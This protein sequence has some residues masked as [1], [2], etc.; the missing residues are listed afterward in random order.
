MA[1][2]TDAR[3]STDAQTDTKT[4]AFDVA[5]RYTAGPHS[6]DVDGPEPGSE[7]FELGRDLMAFGTDA[8]TDFDHDPQHAVDI[9]TE[10]IAEATIQADA[11]ATPFQ[12]AAAVYDR[13]QGPRTDE[14][15]GYD[16]SKTRSMTVG[17]LVIVNGTP[18]M[19][20]RIGFEAV[21]GWESTE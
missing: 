15:L 8:F 14:I 7:P 5:V 10:R 1:Q 21:L 11:D 19:V 4:A 18:I 20:D 17:D 16:G 3:D 2:Q 12:V 9:G 6:E 13:M